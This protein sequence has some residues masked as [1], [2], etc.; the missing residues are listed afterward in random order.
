MGS[1]SRFKI[2]LTGLAIGFTL[3]IAVAD[4]IVITALVKTGAVPGILPLTL[5]T[6]INP[7]LAVITA[8][9]VAFKIDFRLYAREIRNRLVEELKRQ[10]GKS[11]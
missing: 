2:L 3:L 4:A 11:T 1:H 5:L 7:L 9:Y 6:I 10:I 8:G